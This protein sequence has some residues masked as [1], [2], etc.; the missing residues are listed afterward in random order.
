MYAVTIF[1]SNVKL[2]QM[3]C[4]SKFL[5]CLTKM[6]LKLDRCPLSQKINTKLAAFL[7]GHLICY[8]NGECMYL[9]AAVELIWAV[10]LF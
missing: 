5:F 3:S 2:N 10:I 4:P 6:M 9:L 7:T 1:E 8:V